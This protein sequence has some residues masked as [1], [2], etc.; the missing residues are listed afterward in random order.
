MS[1]NYDRLT[2]FEREH[3]PPWMT[4][5]VWTRGR[6]RMSMNIR[7]SV[8]APIEVDEQGRLT[9][10]FRDAGK[11]L[12]KLIADLQEVKATYD[13]PVKQACMANARAAKAAKKSRRRRRR[14]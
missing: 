5:R 2:D 4:Q 10:L 3:L 1:V 12:P 9:F 11:L 7:V 13:F 6:L 8:E 14:T